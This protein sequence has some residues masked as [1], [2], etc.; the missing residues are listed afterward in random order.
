MKPT[1]PA[2]PAALAVAL[3]MVTWAFLQGT[4]DVLPKL[5]WTMVPTLLLLG[6]GE[7]FTAYNLWRRIRRR[8]GTRPVEPLMVARMAVLAKASVIAGAVLAGIFAGFLLRLA[9]EL[10]KTVPR[11]DFFVGVGTFVASLVLVGAAVWLEYAC[12]VPKGPDD[13]D[14]DRGASR[15]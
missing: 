10:D 4:Y 3:A 14:R 13:E 5:P 8:P 12:R 2:L 15:A 7:A 11:Q 6:L 1:R 9:P